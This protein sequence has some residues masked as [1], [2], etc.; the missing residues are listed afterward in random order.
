MRQRR[1]WMERLTE[2]AD[3]PGETLPTVPVVELAGDCRVLIENHGGVTEYGACRI[4][5][6]VRYGQVCITGENLRLSR[7][8]KEQ[9][10]ISGRIDSITVVRR[11]K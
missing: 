6:R 8:T 11:G 3:L 7:M 10:V 2:G 4:R 9:L 1:S 5:V